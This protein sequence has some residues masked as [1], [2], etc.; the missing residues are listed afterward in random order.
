MRSM[1]D[2]LVTLDG[3]NRIAN[4]VIS[5]IF[6]ARFTIMMIAY[7]ILRQLGYLTR[8]QRI[9][10]RIFKRDKISHLGETEIISSERSDHNLLLGTPLLRPARFQAKFGDLKGEKY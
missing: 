10:M 1:T 6:N 9:K 4:P 8:S 2:L 5:Y 7:C 3:N